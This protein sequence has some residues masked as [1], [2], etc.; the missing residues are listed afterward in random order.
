VESV[1]ESM[2]TFHIPLVGFGTWK[3][4]KGEVATAVYEAIRVGYR[5]IDAA[6]V[7][8]NQEEVGAAIQRAIGEGL[9]K[10]EDLF[11]TSKLWNN[12]HGD[13][14][15]VESHC[16]DNLQQLGLDYVDL[17]LIHWPW[18]PVDISVTWRSMERLVSLGLTKY[19]GVSN[20]STSRVREI[21]ALPAVIPPVVNQV[22]IHPLWRQDDL[23]K[24]MKA[25]GIQVV[26]Y[27]PLGSPDS[28]EMLNHTG[29]S[30]L[31]NPVVQSVSAECGHSC[32]Q[33]LLRWG[34]QRGYPVL[35]KS[36]NPSRIQENLDI[37]SWS[38]SEEQM[39]RLSSLEPQG[40]LLRGDF[41]VQPKGPFDS[42]I[43]LWGDESAGGL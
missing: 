11:V 10:R 14:S 12:F 39:A 34:V 26:A 13:E 9:V 23:I 3:S 24:N 17:F 8:K 22:E 20:F 4:Q 35:P 21:L 27:S 18:K 36:V 28:S 31:Q 32:G 43:D 7:Y 1:F 25:L 41:F 38:L 29:A 37:L 19:I 15:T 16:R 5:H 42:L 2:A 33:V 30:L 6:W 40:R